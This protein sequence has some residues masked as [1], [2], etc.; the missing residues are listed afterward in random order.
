MMDGLDP[1][2]PTSDGHD[3]LVATLFAKPKTCLHLTQAPECPL[4]LLL[5]WAKISSPLQ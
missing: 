4:P 3:Y 2:S 1:L 5:Q